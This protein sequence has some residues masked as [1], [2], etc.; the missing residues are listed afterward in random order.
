MKHRELF[1][2]ETVNKMS[3]RLNGPLEE[4][5]RSGRTILGER[6]YLRIACRISM[7]VLEL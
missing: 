7:R 2:T 6:L 1:A 5:L 3:S 4:A